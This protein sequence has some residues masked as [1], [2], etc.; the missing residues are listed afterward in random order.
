[1]RDNLPPP[2]KS[3][4]LLGRGKLPITSTLLVGF[5]GLVGVAVATVLAISIIAA[6]Q[7]T[8]E[9]QAQ[10]AQQRLDAAISRIETYLAP[11]AGDVSFLAGQ[12]SRSG[13]IP[14]DDDSRISPLMRGSLGSA[15]Q[16]DGLA[17]VRP[18]YTSVRMRRYIERDATDSIASSL[19]KEGYVHELM[20]AAKRIKQT[21]WRWN[22]VYYV[23]DLGISFLSVIA[24]V[25]RNGSFEGFVLATVPVGQL[26]RLIETGDPDSTM[27]IL[28]ADDGV[29][30]HPL[31]AHGVFTPTVA[32][33]LPSRMEFPDAVLKQGIDFQERLGVESKSWSR[34]ATVGGETYMMLM[35]LEPN[36]SQQPWFVGIYFPETQMTD[37]LNGLRYAGYAALGI[38]AIAVILALLMG[39][40]LAQ[41]IKRLAQA[42][43]A[44]S[45]FD[46]SGKHRPGGSPLRE[47]DAAG[48]AWDTMLGALRWFETYVPRALVG[49]LLNQS[50][51]Q[52]LKPEER[53]VTVMFTDIVGFS[54][55]ATR[56]APGRL[57]NILNRHFGL[58]GQHVEA[59]QGTI[60][61]YIGDSVM[62]FWGAP[63]DDPD[64]ALH[65]VR[66]ALA[67]GQTLAADNRR[68]AKKGL[69]PVRIRIGLHTGPAIVGNVGAP[70]RVNYTLIGD[71]V[72]AAQ[73]LEQ[74]GH[75]FDDGISDCILLASAATVA[76]LPAEIPRQALGDQT[77]R[78]MG[79]FEVYRLGT[80][81]APAAA[82][83]A[84]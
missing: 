54:R 52:G 70:G 80:V 38:L 50:A 40:S 30:A 43:A 61:K 16:I 22:P 76:H 24:P 46:F 59:E 77:L 31:L 67:I 28:T 68:R 72:N 71:T 26:S 19:D 34:K 53:E 48:Q 83:I 8:R 60:D 9:L 27:F 32:H 15:P 62:A 58:I 84:S 10:A 57:A 42:A 49:R 44:V 79:I 74:L 6:R 78:G 21:G 3:W 39:R 66:A 25:R 35:N 17:F 5:A 7:T 65:A 2:A 14:L 1:M 56:H 33:F 81:S 64:H 47:L 36:F 12:L 51:R 4:R 63:S 20:E 13:G 69:K 45:N 11:A 18:D 55:I 82:P 37:Q 75:A 29:V 23:Q 73:R 41:P